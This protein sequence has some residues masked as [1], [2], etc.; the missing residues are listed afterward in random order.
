[1]SVVSLSVPHF[2][3][4]LPFSCLAACVRLV[5]AYYGRTCSE[6]EVRRLLSTG[7]Q[8]TTARAILRVA[9]LGF[10]VQLRFT[11]LGEL[12]AALSAGSPPVVFV[13]T[14]DLDYWSID[15]AHVLVVVGMDVTSL[16]VNDPHLDSAPQQTSLSGFHQ[17]WAA[18]KCMAAFLRPLP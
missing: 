1:M 10:D 3:Q 4:E 13:N 2:K 15:C 16:S 18:N 7:P 17:A 9:T 11:N 5:L 12:N 14:G 6:D 8:G